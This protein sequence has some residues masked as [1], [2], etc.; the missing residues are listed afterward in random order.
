MGQR[1]SYVSTLDKLLQKY[2]NANIVNLIDSS[3][4]IED[5]STIFNWLQKNMEF[6]S[7]T[8]ATDAKIERATLWIPKN[9]YP[10]S[11]HVLG[12]LILEEYNPTGWRFSYP[13]LQYNRL[14]RSHR[15][16]TIRNSSLLRIYNLRRTTF[17]QASTT[18]TESRKLWLQSM[19]RQEF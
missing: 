14:W 10:A 3:Y 8:T 9:A 6:T 7:K 15:S 18:T 5:N 17:K 4:I 16:N 11:V 2:G 1:Y 13:R 19:P 12:K